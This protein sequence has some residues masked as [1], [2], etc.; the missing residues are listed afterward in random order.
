MGGHSSLSH[1]WLN[2]SV[3]CGNN[4]L[5]P[6]WKSEQQMFYF[7][8]FFATRLF[9][10]SSGKQPLNA[11]WVPITQSLAML[12]TSLSFQWHTFA[13]KA[14]LPQFWTIKLFFFNNKKKS[15][16]HIHV[17]YT[18]YTQTL[19][20]YCSLSIYSNSILQNSNILWKTGLFISNVKLLL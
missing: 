15:I 1:E 10:I 3:N 5:P 20:K 19:V 4:L 8:S 2:N 7:L 17:Q 12:H 18:A 11:V 6:V 9:F 16:S 14:R 13:L